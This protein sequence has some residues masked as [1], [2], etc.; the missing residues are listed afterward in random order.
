M[1]N[2]VVVIGAG[3]TGRGFLGRLLQEAGK[4][5]IFIDK[6]PAL[7]DKLNTEKRF[8]AVITCV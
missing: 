7:V 3:K 5:I 1:T 2:K 6:D 8:S 4:Q